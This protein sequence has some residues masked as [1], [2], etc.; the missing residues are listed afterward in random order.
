MTQKCPRCGDVNSVSAWVSGS[1][2]GCPSCG[3]HTAM[4]KGSLPLNRQDL[5][6]TEGIWNGWIREFD[7][8]LKR[9]RFKVVK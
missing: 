9:R 5:L 2:Y 7:A 1:A 6:T 4:D 8:L 3:Y